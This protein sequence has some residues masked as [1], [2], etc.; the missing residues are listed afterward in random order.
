MKLEQITRTEMF[1]TSHLY[2]AC[3]E[4]IQDFQKLLLQKLNLDKNTKIIDYGFE[5]CFFRDF[6]KAGLIQ[7]LP[8]QASNRK[9]LE[10]QTFDNVYELSNGSIVLVEA[11]AQGK[12][13][14]NQ[15]ISI[16]KAAQLIENN[17]SRLYNKVYIIGLCSSKYSPKENTKSYFNALLNW[18]ELSNIFPFYKEVFDRANEIYND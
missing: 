5:V 17:K 11:K 1:F 4:N 15:I 12:F 3:K 9:S 16:Q 8:K 2:F 13:S 6:A 14:L 7:R 18:S 10:K